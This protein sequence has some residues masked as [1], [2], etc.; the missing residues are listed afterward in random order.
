MGL[1]RCTI[2]VFQYSDLHLTRLSCLYGENV[3]TPPMNR[4]FSELGEWVECL[5]GGFAL[6]ILACA[7]LFLD[8]CSEVQAPPIPDGWCESHHCEEAVTYTATDDGMLE[9]LNPAL[10]RYSDATGRALSTDPTA[11]IPVIWREHLEDSEGAIDE[12]TGLVMED[13]AYTSSVGWPESGM[14]FAQA[15]YLDPTPPDGCPEPAVSLLHELIHAMAPMSK[16]VDSD[17]LFAASTG[18]M[19]RDIDATALERLCENFDCL[20]FRPESN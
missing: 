20:A 11:G 10:E 15:I 16:H 13:C 19:E 8:G 7:V 3:Y 17:S 1:Q 12:A 18:P 5:A 14:V 6:V 2:R 4:F 9:I